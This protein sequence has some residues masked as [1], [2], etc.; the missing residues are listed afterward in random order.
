VGQLPTRIV[1]SYL[2]FWVHL[3]KITTKPA[4]SEPAHV[5]RA[6]CDLRTMPQTHIQG[7]A[8]RRAWRSIAP[9]PPASG[10]RTAAAALRLQPVGADGWPRCELAAGPKAP[11]PRRSPNRAWSG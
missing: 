7:L 1:L 6:G 9:L 2:T 5:A 3:V 10:R 8:P 4:E 11:Q